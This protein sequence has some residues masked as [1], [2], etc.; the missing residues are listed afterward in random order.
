MSISPV[1][2]ER[3]L[4]TNDDGISASGLTALEGIANALSNDVWVVAPEA[5]QSGAGHSLTLTQP[6]RIKPLG[7]KRFAVKGTPTDCVMLALNHI[8]KDNKPTLVLSGVNRGVNLGE[9]LTYSGTIAGAMEGTLAGIPS[10]AM[11][12]ALALKTRKADWQV[13]NR[14]GTDLV[15]RLC[16]EGWKTDTF[17]NINF[18][19][20]DVDAVK[21]IRVTEQGHRDVAGISVEERM[22]MRGF[23]YYWFG[24]SRD[25]GTPG[26]DTDLQ[27][28]RDGFI[29][30]TPLHLEL[31]HFEMRKR[32]K[33][34]IE[35]DF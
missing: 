32:L 21:G 34:T 22:D 14:Y 35:I 24:L 25:F 27:V 17:I 10:I 9:D 13:A 18:P 30:V 29:S 15:R 11:S 23:P 20:C 1:S 28:V 5:E 33:S 31:T 8:L 7:D 12:Q 3:I 26:D 16:E 4:V 6:M 2:F 19:A